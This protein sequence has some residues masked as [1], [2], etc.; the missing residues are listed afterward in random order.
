MD[1][2]MGGQGNDVLFGGRSWG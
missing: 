2:L 1:T